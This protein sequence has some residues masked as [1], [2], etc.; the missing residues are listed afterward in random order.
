M[1]NN[2]IGIRAA[3]DQEFSIVENGTSEGAAH[4]D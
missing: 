1:R 3:S 4:H 2:P